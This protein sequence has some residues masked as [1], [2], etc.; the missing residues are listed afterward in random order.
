MYDFKK[1]LNCIAKDST[2]IIFTPRSNNLSNL[3]FGAYWS[4]FHAPRHVNIFNKKSFIVF[5]E[6]NNFK[7]NVH[8]IFDPLSL[9][10]SSKNYLVDLKI[11]LTLFKVLTGIKIIFFFIFNMLHK[12]RLIVVCNKN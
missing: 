5:S 7:A 4:G 11:K 1:L 2:L 9:L 12:S 3:T 10:V 8:T 6:F